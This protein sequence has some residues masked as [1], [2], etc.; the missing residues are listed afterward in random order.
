MQQRQVT[1]M[2]TAREDPTL[3]LSAGGKQVESSVHA[4]RTLF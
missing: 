3:Q 2:P 4:V 1:C